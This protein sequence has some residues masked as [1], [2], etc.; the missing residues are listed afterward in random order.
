M[1]DAAAGIR[2]VADRLLPLSTL[3]T[4]WTAEAPTIACARSCARRRD[5]TGT[6]A[7]P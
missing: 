5:A 2:S 3:A 7:R 1:E 6:P 4:G